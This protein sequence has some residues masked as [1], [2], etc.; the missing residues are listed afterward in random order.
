MTT[1]HLVRHAT[2]AV[3]GQGIVGR[4]GEIPLSAEG[5]AQADRLAARLARCPVRAV[6]SSPLPRATQTAVPI[7]RRFGL[8][9]EVI[10]GANE[11]DYGDWTGQA[12]DALR[13]MPRWGLFNSFRSFTRIPGG[14]LIVEVQAR[15]VGVMDALRDRHPD[16]HIVI[17]SHGDV[18][19]AALAYALGLPLDLAQ[20]L[21]IDP[22]SISTVVLEPYG[23]EVT[24]INEVVDEQ[25]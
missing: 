23:L 10:E 2:H 16:D 22:A 3:L 24:R 8:K 20:R 4:A 25:H 11:L 14:E 5:C 17:V 12:L 1:F 18:I 21:A 19:R 9:V 15:I 13:R 7:A 6:Y